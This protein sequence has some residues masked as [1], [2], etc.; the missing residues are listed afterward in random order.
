MKK[1]CDI[2]LVYS[3]NNS[4]SPHIPYSVISVAAFIDKKYQVEIFDTYLDN[5]NEYDMTSIKI[6]GISAISGIYIKNA[7]SVAKKIK[8]KNPEATFVWGGQ[9][10]SALPEEVLHSPYCDIVVRGEGE[11]TFR[12]LASALIE[13]RDYSTIKGISYKQHNKIYHTADRELMDLNTIDIRSYD[14]FIRFNR[15]P[16]LKYNFY[17]ESSRGCPYRC[18]FCSFDI[19]R[20]YRTKSPQKM[21]EDIAYLKNKYNFKNLILIEPE[22][23]INRKKMEE[24]A[25]LLIEKKLDITWMA[26]CRIDHFCKFSDEFLDNLKKS[27]CTRLNFGAESGSDKILKH[28]DKKVTTKDIVQAAQKGKGSGIELQMSFMCGFPTE[29]TRDI[30]ETMNMIELVRIHG[31]IVVGWNILVPLP[32]SKLFYECQK[33]GFVPPANLEEWGKDNLSISKTLWYAPWIDR[34]QKIFLQFFTD[35]VRIFYYH[36][37][38]K[39][40]KQKNMLKATLGFFKGTIPH[41]LFLVLNVPCEHR[42]KIKSM[43]FPLDI[44]LYRMLRNVF[45]KQM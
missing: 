5:L 4:F 34:K 33:Y 44:A 1:K 24:F 12:E 29:T 43:R 25:L 26:N 35:I 40:L 9:H 39:K 30:E 28:I 22:A 6:V 3:W 38:T 19:G 15:Y 23:F 32:G 37:Y 45:L 18:A 31:V 10:A 36:D 20:I 27:G 16:M 2:L 14:R 7:I 11:Y 8:A 17:Y 41:Y 21:V 42:W 13:K